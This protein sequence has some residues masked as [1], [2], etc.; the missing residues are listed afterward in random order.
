[1]VE[2]AEVEAELVPSDGASGGSRAGLLKGSGGPGLDGGCW[3]VC[4]WLS[5]LE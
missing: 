2:K 3:I 1:M 5:E 4:R